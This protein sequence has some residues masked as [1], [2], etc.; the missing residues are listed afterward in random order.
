MDVEICEQE[1]C[2]LSMCKV[3]RASSKLETQNCAAQNLRSS[4]FVFLRRT[5]SY[6]YYLH[7][8][9]Q[10][11]DAWLDLDDFEFAWGYTNSYRW[12]TGPSSLDKRPLLLSGFLLVFDLNEPDITNLPAPR[13]DERWARLVYKGWRRKRN[14]SPTALPTYLLNPNTRRHKIIESI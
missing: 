13:L 14:S 9:G 4:C 11:G 2:V 6:S 12:S 10:N 3:H 8:R 7:A 1:L 5:Y